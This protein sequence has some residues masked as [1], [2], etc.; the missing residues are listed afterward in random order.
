MEA[1]MTNILRT[2]VRRIAVIV[3]NMMSRTMLKLMLK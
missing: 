2:L 3:M 1:K